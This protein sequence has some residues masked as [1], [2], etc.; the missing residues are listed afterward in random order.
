MR[1]GMT[2][3][4]RVN[5]KM[6]ITNSCGTSVCDEIMKLRRGDWIW[7]SSIRKGKSCQII[8]VP[9]PEDGRVKE[10]EGEKD[11]KYRYF[12]SELRR[13]CSVRTSV[14]IEIISLKGE[15]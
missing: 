8:E 1:S 13:R 4:L 6:A 11:E 3:F 9:I 14:V 10:K 12:T 7:C 2:I 5:L 15:E